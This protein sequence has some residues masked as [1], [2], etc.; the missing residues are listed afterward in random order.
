MTNFLIDF[1]MDF[2]F[3]CFRTKFSRAY[4]LSSSGTQ[5]SQDQERMRGEL[6]P[7]CNDCRGLVMEISRS[8]KQKRSSAR[9]R[10][11]KNLTLDLSPVWK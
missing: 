4:T 2:Y 7:V 9:N 1:F 11:L 8:A 5:L 10:T 6:V 3:G